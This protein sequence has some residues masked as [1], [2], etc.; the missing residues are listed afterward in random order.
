MSTYYPNTLDLKTPYKCFS[1]LL[2][3]ETGSILVTGIDSTS[4]KSFMYIKSMEVLSVDFAQG[5]TYNYTGVPY[6]AVVAL[7]RTESVGKTFNA[8]IKGTYEYTKAK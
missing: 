1:A 4:I 6:D 3:T 8:E 2:L 5:T 7:L